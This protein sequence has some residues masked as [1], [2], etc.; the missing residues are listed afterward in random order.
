MTDRRRLLITGSA[1]LVSSIL[2]GHWG[3]RY[4]LRLTDIVP[5]PDPG[6]H[7]TLDMDITDLDAFRAA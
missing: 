7:D 3:D 2:R 5:T 1:G 6:D 4:V